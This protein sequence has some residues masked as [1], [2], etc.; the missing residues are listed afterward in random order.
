MSVVMLGCGGKAAQR[1][2]RKKLLTNCL[3]Q[4]HNCAL[5]VK[6]L[7]QPSDKI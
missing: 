2:C 1:S 7:E 6:T 3:S 4:I 5:I